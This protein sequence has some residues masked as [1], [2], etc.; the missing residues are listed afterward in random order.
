MSVVKILFKIGRQMSTLS[1]K[2]DILLLAINH[3]IGILGLSCTYQ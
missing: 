1:S 3:A 2:E